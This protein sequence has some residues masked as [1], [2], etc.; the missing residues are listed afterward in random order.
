MPLSVHLLDHV[1]GVR[2]RVVITSDW[3]ADARVLNAEW[4]F[5]RGIVCLM[6]ESATFDEVPP[7]NVAPE[8]TP[9]FFARDI[10]GSL[11]DLFKRM[12]EDANAKA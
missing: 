4:D 2:P 6:V 9:T 12:D 1:F 11:M 5:P 7:G 3:P 8:W 10:P